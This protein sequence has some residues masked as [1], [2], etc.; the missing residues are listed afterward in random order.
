MLQHIYV[1]YSFILLPFS[2]ILIF[3]YGYFNLKGQLLSTDYVSQM[4]DFPIFV[5]AVNT[6]THYFNFNGITYI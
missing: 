2:D 3:K 1:L 4:I 5:S 6:L